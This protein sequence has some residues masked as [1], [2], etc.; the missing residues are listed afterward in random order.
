MLCENPQVKLQVVQT[1]NPVT[2]LPSAAGPPD[3]DH[4]ELIT[5]VISRH[6]DLGNQLLAQPDLELFTDGSSF[7]K[8]GTKHDGYAGDLWIQSWKSQALTPSTSAQKAELI[9]LTRTLPR[10]AEKTV[11]IYT[12]S[13][14]TF[15]TLH[16]HGAINKET[17]LIT[18]GGKDIKYELEILELLQAVWAP[19]MVAVMYCPGHQK[20][21]SVVALGK[22]RAD[23]EAHAA[24]LWVSPNL[25]VALSAGLLPTPL[26]E[27]V[28][29]YFCHECECFTQE[30]G[31]YCRANVISL[32]MGG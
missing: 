10:A 21:K 8:E 3:H 4:V 7:L 12:D 6:P 16:V 24:S 19:K 23:Q 30:G 9:A 13:K 27:C 20:G 5:E 14:Y 1:L 31:K 32:Q 2:L 11:N 28:P 25:P 29:H 18:S 22:Q 17:G 15:T 26:T